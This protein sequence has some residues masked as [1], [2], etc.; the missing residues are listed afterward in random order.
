M[1]T[2]ACEIDDV[3]YCK[4]RWH[5]SE[6]TEVIS[7]YLLCNFC[8][9]LHIYQF[10]FLDSEFTQCTKAC[11]SGTQRRT[12]KCLEPNTKEKLL[13]ETD[14]CR[15]SE[16]LQAFR[17][18]NTHECE[19]DSHSSDIVGEEERSVTRR[20]PAE[21][22]VELIQND[23]LPGKNGVKSVIRMPHHQEPTKSLHFQHALINIPIAI[24]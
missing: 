11:G 4:P 1:T 21:P 3:T 13:R 9:R 10:L 15:Y 24:S 18:C 12:I 16:R 17:H 2:E 19:N 22:K 6:W 14:N 20:R 5:Y 7:V 23:S 8:T